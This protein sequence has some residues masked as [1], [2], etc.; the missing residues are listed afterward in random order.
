VIYYKACTKCGGDMHDSRD[1]YGSYVTC[2]Q[3]G[4]LKDSPRDASELTARIPVATDEPESHRR[5]AA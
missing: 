5:L 1:A 3:C 4:F 2:M